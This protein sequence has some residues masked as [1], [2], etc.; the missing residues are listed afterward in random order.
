MAW[1]LR[2]QELMAMFKANGPKRFEYLVKKVVDEQRLW[3]LKSADGWVQMADDDGVP[4]FPV[5]PHQAYAGKSAIEDWSDCTPEAIPLEAWLRAWIP[6]LARDGRKV[7]VF[8]TPVGAGVVIPPADFEAAL[9][10]EMTQY[11]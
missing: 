11:E 1:I 2:D 4:L 8:P 5:W 9:R 6:G 7:A 3:S 10:E